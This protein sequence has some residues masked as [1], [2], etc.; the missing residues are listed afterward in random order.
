[1]EVGAV[2]AP[3]NKPERPAEVFVDFD[4]WGVPKFAWPIEMPGLVR[5]RLAPA[6]SA[7]IPPERVAEAS[8]AYDC[9]DY[10]VACNLLIA[11]LRAA[12]ECA[13]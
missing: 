12:R 13:S 4:E 9:G 3:D 7:T 2:M 1:M 6:G 11:F 10:R 8:H 5:Y